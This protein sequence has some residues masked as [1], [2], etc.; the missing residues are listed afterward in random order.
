MVEIKMTNPLIN[1]AVYIHAKR[2]EGSWL[3]NE[4]W[5]IG[6]KIKAWRWL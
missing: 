2:N 5:K 3:A 4:L 1:L 6:I